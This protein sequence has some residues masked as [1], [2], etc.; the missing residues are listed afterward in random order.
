MVLMHVTNFVF[1][2]IYSFSIFCAAYV[3]IKILTLLFIVIREINDLS[4]GCW[5]RTKGKKMS[6]YGLMAKKKVYALSNY[7]QSC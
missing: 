5:P 3:H 7:F 1:I 2:Y 4:R 6:L